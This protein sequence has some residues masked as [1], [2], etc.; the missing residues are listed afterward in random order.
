MTVAERTLSGAV[1]RYGESLIH[2]LHGKAGAGFS[3]CRLCY[4]AVVLC[5]VSVLYRVGASGEGMATACRT[6]VPWPWQS[7]NSKLEM[8]SSDM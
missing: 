2:R 7:C 4:L 1:G 8:L 5:V 6:A 3:G